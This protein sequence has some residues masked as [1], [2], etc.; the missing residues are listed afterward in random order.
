MG[1]RRGRGGLNIHWPPPPPPLF[2]KLWLSLRIHLKILIYA[3]SD[4]KLFFIHKMREK[5]TIRIFRTKRNLGS[6]RKIWKFRNSISKKW[7]QI[8]V[9]F[10]QKNFWEQSLSLKLSLKHLELNLK[11]AKAKNFGLQS[12]SLKLILKNFK[13]NLKCAKT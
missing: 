5:I 9:H 2:R 6:G 12:P 1:R 7:F 11:C 8:S 10:L 4:P 13:L 3:I